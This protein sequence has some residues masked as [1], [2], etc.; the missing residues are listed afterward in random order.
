MKTKKT[1]MA[2]L[3]LAAALS[4]TAQAALHDRGSGLIYDDVLNVT[5]LQDANYGA[6]SSYDNGDSTTDGQMTWQNAVNWAANLSYYDSIRHVTYVDWRL[7]SLNPINGTNIIWASS[8]DG[9]TDFGH[10]VTS[11]QNEL[12]YMYYVNLGNPGYYSPT[13]A[14]NGC[15]VGIIACLKNVGSFANLQPSAYWSGEESTPYPYN[16]AWWAFYMHEGLQYDSPKVYT[17]YAWALRDGDVAAIPEAD[18]WAMLL[19]GLG[20]VSAVARRKRQ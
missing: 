17:G 1:R 10:N 5:W 12:S 7:P 19:A 14:D 6:G 11:T 16:N 9:S 3:V 2:F 15:Y 20:L 18:T 4:G 8:Y 13:G